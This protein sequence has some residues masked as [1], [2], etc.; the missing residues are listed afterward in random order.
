MGQLR[1][2]YL[3]L[4]VLLVFSFGCSSNKGKIEGTKWISEATTMKGVAVPAGI[5]QLE[6]GS[7]GALVSRV[8]G[9]TFTGRYSLGAGDLVTFNFDKEQ[10]GRKSHAEKISVNGESLTMTDS[11]GTK[12]IFKSMK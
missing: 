4:A 11:D 3:L 12:L 1:F 5:M 6:F 9:E 8:G 7:D 2:A 10:A